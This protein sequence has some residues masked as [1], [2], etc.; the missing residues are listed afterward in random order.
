MNPEKWEEIK[1]KIEK[2]FKVI[3][4]SEETL[5]NKGKQETIEFESPIGI[6]RLEFIIQPRVLDKKT[7]YS[8]RAGGQTN[9]EYIYSDDEM[10]SYLKVYKQDKETKE[11]EE[12]KES[13]F[14]F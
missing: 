13:I 5:E 9:V 12:I 7:Q 8:H 4:K 3:T 1:E 10:S 6:V 11:W 2:K 14:S